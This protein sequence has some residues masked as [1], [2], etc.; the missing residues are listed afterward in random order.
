MLV[1]GRGVPLADLAVAES[2]RVA[3]LIISPSL[4]RLL[5]GGYIWG[6]RGGRG[7]SDLSTHLLRRTPRPLNNGRHIRLGKAVF[8]RRRLKLV[9]QLVKGRR[10]L[11]RGSG[12]QPADLA[13]EAARRLRVQADDV[14]DALR[15]VEQVLQRL[16]IGR[17][18]VGGVELV[19]FV[20][21]DAGEDEA[22]EL[23]GGRTPR[24]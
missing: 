1:G 4:G 17:G 23:V 18:A 6:V 5:R 16:G 2:D 24:G 9:G 20:G 10:P 19:E 14:G 13:R 15:L 8:L 7:L 11:R 22:L 3:E 12:A 21:L